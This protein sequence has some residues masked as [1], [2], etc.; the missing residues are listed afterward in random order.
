M[1]A[2]TAL[3][4]LMTAI[5]ERRWL[6]LGD[7]L[8]PEFICRLVHTGETFSRDQWIALNAEYPGFEGLRVEEIV[9]GTSAAACRSH[10]TSRTSEGVQHFEC[11]SFA[12]MEDGVISRLTEVWADTDQTPPEGARPND[13][14]AR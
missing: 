4:G 5:D 7:Y 13:G 1:D 10:V 6:D 8:H 12:Q 2:E 11:A 3:R 14:E 9:G